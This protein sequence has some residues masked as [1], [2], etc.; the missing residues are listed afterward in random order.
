M[1]INQ[2]DIDLAMYLL[3]QSIYTGQSLPANDSALIKRFIEALLEHQQRPAENVKSS[4]WRAAI[5]R[6][7]LDDPQALQQFT[8]Q[9]LEKFGPENLARM[10]A[11]QLQELILEQQIQTTNSADLLELLRAHNRLTDILDYAMREDEEWVLDHFGLQDRIDEAYDT[12]HAEGQTES[13]DEYD[14]GYLDGQ[15]AAARDAE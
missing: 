4:E 13:N 1:A 15:N 8:Q 7:L 12:G 6:K 2:N 3:D 11:P 9:A 10:V 5:Y 14:R